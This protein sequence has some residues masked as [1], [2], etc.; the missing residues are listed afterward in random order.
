MKIIII[1]ILSLTFIQA[2]NLKLHN[3]H[4]N[5]KIV[6]KIKN[7]EIQ[8]KKEINYF[9]RDF[10]TKEVIDID[11][12][13]LKNLYKIIKLNKL[14]KKEIKIISGY[15]SSKTNKNLKKEF[16][17]NVAK[18][19]LHMEGKAIDFYIEN[20]NLKN[21]YEK[22]KKMN[23]GGIGYYKKDNFIHIDTGKVKFWEIY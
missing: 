7:G 11:N 8:N 23:L 16:K 21:I 17:K 1:F 9:L 19:S 15:R 10:R 2:N 6:L 5:E 14:E 4:T 13:L 3:I 22:I 12:N 18:R 20:I